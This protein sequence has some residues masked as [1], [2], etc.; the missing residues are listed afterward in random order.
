MKVKIVQTGFYYEVWVKKFLMW[1]PVY[2]GM[3]P[4]R[5]S[6]KNAMKIK[7]KFN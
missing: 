3:F 1:Q 2:D 4:L 6:Y 7:K 5:T